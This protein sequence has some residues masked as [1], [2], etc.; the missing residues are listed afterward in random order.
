MSAVEKIRKTAASKFGVYA[1]PVGI[2]AILGLLLTTIACGAAAPTIG[3]GGANT[4]PPSAVTL[5]ATPAANGG[6]VITWDDPASTDVDFSH[7]LLSWSPDDGPVPGPQRINRGVETAAVA[8][9]TDGVEYVFTAVSFDIAGNHSPAST[10][11]R[12]TADAAPTGPVGNLTATGGLSQVTLEWTDPS[13]SDFSHVLISWTPAA[14][15]PPESRRVEPGVQTDTI[16]NLISSQDYNFTVTTVD[17]LGNTIATT[18]AATTLQDTTPPGAVALGATARTNGSVEVTWTNPPD[19]DFSH[20]LLSWSPAD[21]PAPQPLNIGSG[22][23]TAAVTGLTNGTQY[24]FTAQSVD[25]SGNVSD[26]SAPV[27]ATANAATLPVTNLDTAPGAARVTVTWTD[28]VIDDFTHVRITWSPPHGGVTQPLVV[29]PGTQTA[30]LTGLTAGTQYTV[31]ATAVDT[32]G[33]QA[34]AARA[35]TVTADASVPPVTNLAATPGPDSA[36][37]TWTDPGVSDLAHISITWSPPH[38]DIPQPLVVQPGT[39]AALLTGLT[40]GTQYTITA[41]ATDTLGHTAA[42]AAPLVTPAV[43]ASPAVTDAAATTITAAG[44]TTVTWT[45]P[46]QTSA[47]DRISITGTPPG[48]APAVEAPLGAGTAVLT[49]LTPGVNHTITISSLNASGTVLSTTTVTASSAVNRPI[50]LFLLEGTTH[51]GNFGYDACNTDLNSGTAAIPAALRAAG[52]T[53]AV[54]FGSKNTAPSYHFS[55]IATDS[56]ALG[57]DGAEGRDEYNRSV[58]VYATAVPTTTF[59][60]AGSR[61]GID[62]VLNVD[63]GGGWQNGGYDVVDDLVTGEFWSFSANSRSDTRSTCADATSADSTEFGYLGNSSGIDGDASAM[64]AVTRTCQNARA[65]ICAAH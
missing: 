33:H 62:S 45:D 19:S 1:A 36:S 57:L 18:T 13:D 32:F 28:P 53:R 59:G 9:L 26:T 35:V 10:P 24:T 52:Y 34:I 14:V 15:L 47:V 55:S 65:V 61:R 11:I 5:S 2:L 29:Q 46:A 41:T 3:G 48:A 54:L 27:T 25:T 38:G 42:A 30:L 22:A 51:T 21:G 56:A 50:A 49:A 20:I 7:I 64:S 39:Q 37:V 6:V 43:A 17:T 8:G 63:A 23:Q 16:T 4:T 40:A 12:V 44:S 60:T 31:T 58:V